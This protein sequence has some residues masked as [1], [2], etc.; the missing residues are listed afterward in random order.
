[1]IHIKNLSKNYNRLSVLRDISLHIEKG[2]IFGLVG[3]SGV[4]KST[5]LRCINGLEQYNSGS[6]KVDG[7]EVGTL[8]PKALR[9]FRRDVGMIFQNFSLVSRATVYEN[10][11]LPMRFWHADKKE[12]EQKVGEFL[13]IVG[14]PE[15]RNSLARELSG[16]QKQ[17]VAIARTLTMSPK[18]L[19]CDEATSALDPKST[20]SVLSLLQQINR[21][22]GITIIAVTHEMDVVRSLCKEMAILD[23]GS[24]QAVGTVDEIFME[25]PPALRNLLGQEQIVLPTEGSNLEI[26]YHMERQEAYLLSRMAREL[27]VEFRIIKES[28]MKTVSGLISTVSFNLAKSDAARVEAY[29]SQHGISCRILKGEE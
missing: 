26:S 22:L 19:L 20:Q 3:R 5:L 8:E 17:R 25:R 10:I 2:A 14:I 29:F 21:E 28:Q 11:A 15:K 9:F 6:L 16:G 27:Q 4:G 24:V 13:K 7:V 1:M 12:I 23:D 18:L